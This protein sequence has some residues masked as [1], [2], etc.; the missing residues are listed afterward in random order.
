MT[1]VD[2]GRELSR[3]LADPACPYRTVW[4]RRGPAYKGYALNQTAVAKVLASYLVD[5]GLLAEFEEEEWPRS[6]RDWV[7]SRLAGDVLTHI[8]LELFMDAFALSDEHRDH[9]RQLLESGTP[10]VFPGELRLNGLADQ[11]R[12]VADRSLDEHVISASGMPTFRRTTQ[13]LRALDDGVDSYHFLVNTERVTVDS[14]TG[15]TPEK[16]RRVGPGVW[17]V[18]ITLD[19]SLDH[20][21]IW[22]LAFETTFD[23]REPP[24]PH[25]RRAAPLHAVEL[26]MAISFDPARL[27]EAVHL[28]T[29]SHLGDLEPTTSVGVRLDG[30]H[31]ARATWTAARTGMVGFSWRW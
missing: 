7:R 17:A 21:E 31:S 23:Y 18:V 6:R 13:R 12:Y 8:E 24:A 11:T 29:W 9:L 1:G 30:A 15:G 22:D 20:G 16:P 27:P 26:E 28:S 2:A 14:C 4:E 19:K 10:A 5:R 25:V 3:L